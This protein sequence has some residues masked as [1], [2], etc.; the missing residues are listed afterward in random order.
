ML[1]CTVLNAQENQAANKSVACEAKADPHSCANA[2]AVCYFGQQKRAAC[3]GQA[4]QHHLQSD[5]H[6]QLFA[7]EPHDYDHRNGEAETGT[8]CAHKK[9]A[10]KRYIDLRVCTTERENERLAETR[11]RS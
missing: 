3:T 10:D 6:G 5:S 7:L 8:A 9:A 4:R 11:S 2:M 1:R